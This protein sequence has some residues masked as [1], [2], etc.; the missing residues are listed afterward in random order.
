VETNKNGLELGIRNRNRLQGKGSNLLKSDGNGKD[1]RD[2]EKGVPKPGADTRVHNVVRDMAT[3]KSTTFIFCPKPGP[4]AP[5]I[6]DSADMGKGK[7]IGF[8]RAKGISLNDLGDGTVGGSI[9]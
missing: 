3:T 1:G 6:R 4:S 2:R 7:G 8:A 5:V 9:A